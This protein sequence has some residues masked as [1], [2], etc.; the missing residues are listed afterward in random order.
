MAQRFPRRKTKKRRRILSYSCGFD[1]ARGLLHIFVESLSMRNCFF[2][3]KKFL[4]I[5]Y[6]SLLIMLTDTQVFTV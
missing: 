6:K 1:L 5:Q 2:L 4:A 3:P